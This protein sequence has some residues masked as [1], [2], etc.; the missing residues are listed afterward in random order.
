MENFHLSNFRELFLRVPSMDFA[1]VG[2]KMTAQA[3][4]LQRTHKHRKRIARKKLTPRKLK[5][6]SVTPPLRAVVK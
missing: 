3:P 2:F 5:I 1:R 4:S 6:I